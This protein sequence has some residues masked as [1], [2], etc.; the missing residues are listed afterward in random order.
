MTKCLCYAI[1][2]VTGVMYLLLLA[3]IV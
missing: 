1:G 2:G 3:L